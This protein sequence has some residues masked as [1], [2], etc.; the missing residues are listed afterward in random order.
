MNGMNTLN[1]LVHLQVN[2]QNQLDKEIEEIK[3]SHRLQIDE[4]ALHRNEI[5]KEVEG[6]HG[7]NSDDSIF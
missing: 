1:D 7:Y 4:S 5:T 2:G 6:E 3:N